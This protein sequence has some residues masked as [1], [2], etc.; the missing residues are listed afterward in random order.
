MGETPIRHI[1]FW[2]KQ[3]HGTPSWFAG[4]CSNDGWE[5]INL[6][7][8]GRSRASK[9]RSKPIALPPLAVILKEL[10]LLG[11]TVEIQKATCV[12]YII[13]T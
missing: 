4:H 9:L 5:Q 1:A 6:A 8:K 2:M 10:L 11:L 7:L 3:Y 12:Y 13:D